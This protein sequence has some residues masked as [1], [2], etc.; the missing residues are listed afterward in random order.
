M[1]T[2]T[3]AA[4]EAVPKQV[5]ASGVVRVPA[6]SRAPQVLRYGGGLVALSGLLLLAVSVVRQLR[7][8]EGVEGRI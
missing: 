3:R 8:R 1:W 4:D 5:L 6:P 2:D 7:R